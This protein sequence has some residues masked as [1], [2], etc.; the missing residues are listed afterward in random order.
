MELQK[1]WCYVVTE[2]QANLKPVGE[3]LLADMTEAVGPPDLSN[4]AGNA[5]CAIA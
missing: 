1:N 2:F 4:S 5:A 3:P